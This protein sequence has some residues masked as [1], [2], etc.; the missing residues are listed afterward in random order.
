[1]SPLSVDYCARVRAYLASVGSPLALDLPPLPAVTGR[2]RA[3]RGTRG[4]VDSARFW[5]A[6]TRKVEAPRVRRAGRQAASR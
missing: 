1:M 6:W 5:A 3:P 2:A 4:F